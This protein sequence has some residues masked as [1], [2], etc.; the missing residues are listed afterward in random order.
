MLQYNIMSFFVLL[1]IYIYIYQLLVG[2]F[3]YEGSVSRKQFNGVD[4]TEF[5]VTDPADINNRNGRHC[6]KQ[7]WTQSERACCENNKGLFCS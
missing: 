2:P 7:N 4:R 3:F 5:N 6:S 1:D